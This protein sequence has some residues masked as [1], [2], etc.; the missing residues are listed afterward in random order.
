M[1]AW[2]R[3][4]KIASITLASLLTL[5]LIVAA[6]LLVWI[7]TNPRSVWNAA[8]E[9]F[10]PDDM[11]VTWSHLDF[12]ANKESWL[13]WD[14][15]WHLKGVKI[16]K[17]T[18]KVDITVDD[19]DVAVTAQFF[20]PATR[21]VIHQLNLRSQTASSVHLAPSSEN[22]PESSFYETAA[23]I[24]DYLEMARSYTFAENI[25]IEVADF[26]LYSGEAPL[27]FKA[28]LVKS[29]DINLPIEIDAS[30]VS[31]KPEMKA[32]LQ[33]Q[34]NLNK[35][36]NEE[37]FADLRGGFEGFNTKTELP[38]Q[39]VYYED[40]LRVHSVAQ[41][42]YKFEKDIL[43]A[44][45]DLTLSL[46]PEKVDLQLT[47]SIDGIPGPM[48]K[49]RDLRLAMSLPL[50]D[51]KTW[52]SQPAGFAASAPVEVFFLEKKL[53]RDVEKSCRCKFPSELKTDLQGKIWF[54]PLIAPTSQKLKVVEAQIAMESV[55]NQIFTLNLGAKATVYRN[56]QSWYY[57]PW[58]DSEMTI[59]KLKPF[60][61]VFDSKGVLIP[62]P[63][64]ILDGT[65]VVKAKSPVEIAPLKER[66]SSLTAGATIDVDLKSAYQ[67][68]KVGAVAKVKTN[69]EF[70]NFDI[71][72]KARIEKLQ[73]TLP[74]IEPIAGVPKLTRDARI[75][76]EPQTQKKSNVK[77]TVNFE[78][79]TVKP[80]AIQL[81]SNLAKPFVP[82]TVNV[83]GQGANTNGSIKL[84]AF[85]LEYLRRSLLVDNFEL[86]LK[87]DAK[88]DFPI[89]GN[90]RV[91]QTE[92]VI[93][94]RVT[95]T[96]GS[97]MIQLSSDPYLDRADIISVLL[98]DRTRDQLAGGDAESVGNVQAAM[99][100]R[101]IGLFGL[102]AFANTPIRSVSYNPAT[103]MYSATVLLGGGLT[104]GI[105]S[106][107]DQ[108]T[109]LQLRK[110]I[111]T[112]WVL[113]ASWEPTTKDKNEVGSIV[114]QWERRF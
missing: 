48:K 38:L 58:I 37:T 39:A 108:S 75:L 105:G 40:V 97:P 14:F 49:L 60:L 84:E 50:E 47:T 90:F 36:G 31:E 3:P 23:Q 112:R 52:S 107:Q 101:A 95:G 44:K 80:G 30:M 81:Y 73:L 32:W 9:W 114:L 76:L 91:K 18:P 110:R 56:T 94:I 45:P 92:Y 72:L 74:P 61:A 103:K 15:E 68:V 34:V 104:A 1:I 10:L 57:D 43:K 24:L 8:S 70:K 19:V 28:K 4:L 54:E 86:K 63:L 96:V 51:G 25:D 106:G 111:S 66:L 109:S 13:H 41:F 67:I 77:V 22:A 35:M 21:I 64:S 26:K 79:E 93:S 53:R 16:T 11:A 55:K 2:R 83:K 6:F 12:K 99:A 5:L 33:G 85:R 69:S 82:A 29:A 113:T 71:D 102:W 59:H 20:S 78:I 27:Q 100:D 42:E 46:A 87:E 62:A 89:A 17:V 7:S 98:Y 65:I 88:G